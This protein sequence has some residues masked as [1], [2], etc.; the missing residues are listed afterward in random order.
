MQSSVS[1]CPVPFEQQPLNEYQELQESWFFRWSTLG[2]SQYI[3]KLFW[4]WGWSWI[5]AGPIAAASF[6]IAKHPAQFALMG[7]AGA[8][9]LLSLVLL[10]LYL[11]WT[12]IRSRL[13][14][15]TV[16]YEE[17]GWYDGQL[18]AKPPEMLAQDQLVVT[19]QIQPIL[20]RLT[21]TFG[22]LAIALLVGSLVWKLL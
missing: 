5:V 18:W 12:Y 11:G 1:P 19:Y 7:M 14:N 3:R 2:L 6:S 15:A 8:T 10:R 21:Q 20:K 16:F 4:L 13:S 22:V 17:S 9:L